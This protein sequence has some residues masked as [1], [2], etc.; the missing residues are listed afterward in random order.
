MKQL[1]YITIVLSALFAGTVPLGAQQAGG[2]V[3]GHVTDQ[4]TQQPI[5]GATVTIGKR[6]A[7][8]QADGR[9]SITLPAGTYTLHARTIGY[10]PVERSVT[11][12][13]GQTADVDIALTAQATS[14]SAIIVTGYG[15]QRAGDIT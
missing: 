8:T 4:V 13:A 3:R 15:E 10:A 1:R 11:V 5:T 12:V 7:L 9:Y 14:L 6:G 2:T